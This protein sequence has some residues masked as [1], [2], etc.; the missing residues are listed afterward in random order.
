MSVTF[1]NHHQTTEVKGIEEQG[2]RKVSLPDPLFLY[3]KIKFL[4]VFLNSYPRSSRTVYHMNLYV[5]YRRD[6]S[7]RLAISVVRSHFLP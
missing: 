3:E 6:K 2:D 7:K 4:D 1:Q 5:W